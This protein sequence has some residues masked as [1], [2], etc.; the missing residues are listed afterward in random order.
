MT[1]SEVIFEFD[2]PYLQHVYH[3]VLLYNAL[4]EATPVEKYVEEFLHHAICLWE[5]GLEEDARIQAG[6][7]H[8]LVSNFLNDRWKTRLGL[9]VCGDKIRKN[10]KVKNCRYAIEKNNNQVLH[11]DP[12]NHP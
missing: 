6:T 8:W 12:V 10:H 9:A 11:K 1:S 4:N 7:A 3:E 2:L 5:L